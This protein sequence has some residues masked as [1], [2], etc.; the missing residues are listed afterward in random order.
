MNIVK[1][2]VCL[3]AMMLLTSV[4]LCATDISHG[5]MLGAVSEHTAHIWVRTISAT[6]VKFIVRERVTQ[7]EV[8]NQ[9]ILTDASSDFTCIAKFE[10]LKRDTNYL[11]S[12]GVGETKFEASFTTLGPSLKKRPIRLVFGYGYKPDDKMKKLD[13]IFLKMKERNGD[14]VLFL[15]DFPYTKAGRKKEVRKENKVIRDNVG[16]TPLTS[17]IPTYAIWDDHDFG[18]NDCDGTHEYAEEALEGFKEYWPN[19]VY[20]SEDNKGIY[21]AFVIGDIE[22]FLLDGRYH[23]RQTKENATMLGAVQFE[24]LCEG[25][26]KS[27]ARYK[28]LVSGTPFARNKKDCW[29]GSFYRGERDALFRYIVEQDIRGVLAISGDIH[30]CDI[31]KIPLGNNRFLYDFTGGSLARKHRYPPDKWGDRLLY[32]YG[33]AEKN[34]FGEIDFFPADSTDVAVVLRSFSGALGLT[35]QLKLKPRELGLK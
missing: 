16:F 34:M 1:I 2:L 26:K 19:G 7:T 25:L 29:G 20:G 30:R 14:F 3:L 11:Y 8:R 10:G 5:P 28:L 33:S 31:H 15:G 22:V 9:T 13:S 18:P 24:W 27:Q 12:V 21:R 4:R 35:H 32:S 23:A 17:A 6:S